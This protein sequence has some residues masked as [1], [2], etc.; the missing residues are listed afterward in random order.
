MLFSTS[1]LVCA[2]R[3]NALLAVVIESAVEDL[4]V[5]PVDAQAGAGGVLHADVV[6]DVVAAAGDLHGGAAD[7]DGIGAS[8]ESES[9]DHLIAMAAG[10]QQRTRRGR[11]L[12]SPGV[13]V[14]VA[15][16][17]QVDRLAGRVDIESSRRDRRLVRDFLQIGPIHEKLVAVEAAGIAAAA[18]LGTEKVAPARVVVDAAGT[19]LRPTADDIG[20]G[21]EHGGP[22]RR[23]QRHVIALEDRIELVA[24]DAGKHID[25]PAGSHRVQ[26]LLKRGE[27]LGESPRVAVASVGAGADVIG[28]RHGR[29]G[30]ACQA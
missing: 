12:D 29:A 8:G 1:R 27:G 6:D 19:D 22:R 17:L 23:L 10:A 3:G 16:Q 7:L 20:A 4:G 28:L 11:A 18:R 14:R 30:R 26:G 5:G 24:V 2:R 21:N 9:L 13:G 25:R 15:A